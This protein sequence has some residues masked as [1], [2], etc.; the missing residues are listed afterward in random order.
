[1]GIVNR[2]TGPAWQ[3]VRL[4]VPPGAGLISLDFYLLSRESG[5]VSATPWANFSNLSDLLDNSQLSAA[6]RAAQAGDPNAMP[7]LLAGRGIRD[8]PVERARRKAGPKRGGG[9]RRIAL[10]AKVALTEPHPRSGP[11]YRDVSQ[12]RRVRCGGGPRPPKSATGEPVYVVAM[13]EENSVLAFYFLA[14]E[15]EPAV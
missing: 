14:D 5:S 1:L 3:R 11:E 8:I 2:S 12:A 7:R 13:T 10:D 4:A 6:L 9:R 15:I